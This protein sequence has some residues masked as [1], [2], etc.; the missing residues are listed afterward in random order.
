MYISAR[1]YF[2]IAEILFANILQFVI[3]HQILI[4]IC[5]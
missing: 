4:V 2:S 1:K 3:F 5:Y